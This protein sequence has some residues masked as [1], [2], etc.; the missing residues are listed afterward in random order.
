MKTSSLAAPSQSE[1]LP[2]P[3][4]G[5]KYPASGVRYY[6][7]YLMDP[8]TALKDKHC[9]LIEELYSIDRQLGWLESSGP[10]KAPKILVRL[11]GCGERLAGDLSL[12]FQRE[13]R[14][15]YPVLEKRLGNNTEPVVVMKQEHRRLLNCMKSF[16]SEV[17]RMIREHD[18]IKTW[19]LSSALQD[20][21][22]ELSDHM[23]R[24]ER[25]LFWL[26]DLHLSRGD[27][28]KVCFELARMSKPSEPPES[29]L[30]FY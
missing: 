11:L 16:T 7:D 1:D 10:E 26:A 27:R 29:K 4:R 28:N 22:S 2:L 13:E 12:H 6:H 17:S 24:E 9:T 30:G 8:L 20:L 5:N 15:L 3:V 21:R 14:A 19:A 18:A 25:V 23:S